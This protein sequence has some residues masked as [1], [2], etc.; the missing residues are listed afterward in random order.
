MLLCDV[1]TDAR[2]ITPEGKTVA[3]LPERIG[4]LP[5]C[6]AFWPQHRGWHVLQQQDARWP[7]HVRARDAGTGLHAGALRDATLRL[8]SSTHELPVSATT[9]QR[10]GPRWPWFLGWLLA[11]AGIWWLERSRAG[12]RIPPP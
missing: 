7:F 4:G 8:A 3:L 1:A 2:V 12:R 6:A 11:A 9:G 5:A 10:S